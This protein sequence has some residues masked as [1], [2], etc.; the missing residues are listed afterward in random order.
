MLLIYTPVQVSFQGWG[1]TQSNAHRTAK[2]ATEM[3]HNGWWCHCPSHWLWQAR[4][5]GDQ[6]TP[7][8]KKAFYL[9]YSTVT[10]HSL[11]IM[12]RMTT[13]YFR[14]LDQLGDVEQFPNFFPLQ[15]NAIP[16]QIKIQSCTGLLHFE[17]TSGP[18]SST[19]RGTNTWK[20]R[21]RPV[22]QSPDILHCFNQYR[23]VSW[24]Q[25]ACLHQ[26]QQDRA[27]GIQ[28]QANLTVQR[29]WLL[30]WGLTK[31]TGMSEDSPD[32]TKRIFT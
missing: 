26:N 25:A 2:A 11:T 15:H 23:A 32:C 4:G 31:N 5:V 21:H 6:D 29:R 13:V 19:N 20:I 27:S 16:M 9:N 3:S 17:S 14:R 7:I 28:G 8:T 1:S 12:S 18:S 22:N 30:I 24:A 10:V